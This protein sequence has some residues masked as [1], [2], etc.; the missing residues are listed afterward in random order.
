[1]FIDKIQKTIKLDSK[2]PTYINSFEKI[3]QDK[4]RKTAF[5]VKSDYSNII[6]ESTSK[7]VNRKSVRVNHRKSNKSVNFPPKKSSIKTLELKSSVNDDKEEKPK[8]KHNKKVSINV[9]ESIYDNRKISSDSLISDID[10]EKLDNYELNDLDYDS[11]LK[12]DQRNFI[13]I[14][15]ALLK[16]EQLII[17]T[18]FTRNDHNIVFLKVIRLIFLLC[19]DMTTN[20]FFFADETMHK[21]YLDYGK[22]NYIQQIPQIIYS[23]VVA[24]IIEVFLCFLSLTDKHYY[25]IKDLDDDNRY[26][27]FKILK[28]VK[29]KITFFFIFTFLMFLFYWYAVTCFC[30]VYENTQNAFIKDSFSSFGFGLLYPFILYLIPSSLRIISLKCCKGNLSFIY[31]LSDIIPFF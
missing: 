24:Q 16:R 28:C 4:K 7:T 21:M 12:L 23:T 18:F 9:K 19:T 27:T 26:K 6:N 17:F 11:A 31:K 10:I 8:N 25:E 20:V 5:Q 3:K 13:K 22:Y 2:E 30:A 29:T 1:M 14:Y 15:W